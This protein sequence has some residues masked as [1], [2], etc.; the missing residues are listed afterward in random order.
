MKQ[1]FF[2]DYVCIL[3]RFHEKLSRKRKV[4]SLQ[5]EWLTEYEWRN[6]AVS[7]NRR[8]PDW[9]GAQCIYP[10]GIRR[11]MASRSFQ[12]WMMAA[13]LVWAVLMPMVIPMNTQEVFEDYQ[14]MEQTVFS[15]RSVNAVAYSLPTE[16]HCQQQS[17]SRSQLLAGKM[18]LI[19]QHYP[20]PNDLLPPN[21][22]SI[23][24]RGNGMVP[25]RSL[26]AR[27]G[28]ETIE[29]L[30]KLFEKL[31]SEGIDGLYV[32]QGT[33][34]R[35]QQTETLIQKMRMLMKKTMP[36]Q[37]AAWIRQNMEM[38]GTGSLMQEYAVEIVSADGSALESST[39][40]QKLLQ[41]CWRYGFVRESK[42]RPFRF[43]YVGKAHATA[44]TYLDL[45]FESYL[46]W[47][48]QKGMLVVSAG[49]KPQY[50]ILCQ[51]MQGD[52]AAFDLP[53]GAVYEVSMDNT[54]YALAACTL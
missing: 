14:N 35:A 45:D 28:Y 3:I 38:P 19:N 20:L 29:A 39:Q 9:W 26:Q 49:G 30:K 15:A 12:R 51:P 48:H 4:I 33:I 5:R 8:R 11:I 34:S 44:M 6:R 22:A 43:R 16:M 42:E 47:L 53:V 46:A 31:R 24:L 41:L 27:S 54:G 40:G 25:V 1:I 7:K 2:F 37:A 50:L 36:E 21:T 23:A 13:V 18:L 10:T 52:Y 32:Q 17:F